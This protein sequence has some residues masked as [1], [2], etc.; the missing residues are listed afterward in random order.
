MAFL[1]FG[2][3]SNTFVRES[4]GKTAGLNWSGCN[5]FDDAI[6]VLVFNQ[7]GA[8]VLLVRL[9]RFRRFWWIR[10]SCCL[11]LLLFLLLFD[12]CDRLVFVGGDWLRPL[13]LLLPFPSPLYALCGR[14]G[15]PRKDTCFFGGGEFERFGL[16]ADGDHGLPFKASILR[17][18]LSGDFGGA[19]PFDMH[20]LGGAPRHGTSKLGRK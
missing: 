7:Y 15:R 11:L 6:P 5:L 2:I 10:V 13:I 17:R 16:T 4:E 9:R 3:A 8:T 20:S 12:L 14:G 19:R 1:L 18:S